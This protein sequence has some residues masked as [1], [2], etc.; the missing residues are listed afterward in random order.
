MGRV[1]PGLRE[2]ALAFEA[3]RAHRRRARG[4]DARRGDPGLHAGA[5]GGV[6][7]RAHRDDRQH[8]GG[9]RDHPGRHRR[10]DRHPRPGAAQGRHRR[11]RRP[12]A[13]EPGRGRDD[14]HEGAADLLLQL[15]P[16][17]R[18]DRQ[19]RDGYGARLPPRRL[20]TADDPGHPR[21]PARAD[22]PDRRAGRPRQGGRLVLPLPQGQ[23][24]LR[25]PATHVP[26]LLEPLRVRGHQSRRAPEGVRGDACGARHVLRLPPHGRARS[27]RGDRALADLERHRP[28]QPVP[29]SD[30]HQPVPGN[31]L[32]R[33]H[34]DDR[35]GDA[36]G[37]DLELRGGLRPALSRLGG[38][39]PQ[40][41]RPRLRD[42]RQRHG[43]DGVAQ[44][45]R[46][47]NRAG[48]LPDPRVVPPAAPAAELSLVD[49]RQRQLRCGWR[50]WSTGSGISTSRWGGSPPT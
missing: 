1:R 17:C 36:R 32:P 13:H 22:Q 21:Q 29:R 9:A 15:R 23:D 6:P 35:H 16:A 31:E 4:A 12:P 24:R 14:H 20:R 25:R 33:G 48:G 5:G 28:L 41:H 50:R 10:R 40:Q 49:A 11:P 42:L 27:A 34:V 26:P 37:V 43:G 45:P 3:A 19:R 7:P 47:R 2:G 38:D 8:R 18:R 39:E 44:A 30:R 46:R